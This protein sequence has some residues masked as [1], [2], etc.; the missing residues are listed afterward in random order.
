[1]WENFKKVC[2]VVVALIG[3]VFGITFYGT[4]IIE[5]PPAVVEIPATIL[6]GIPRRANQSYEVPS[7]LQ[8]VV[9][10]I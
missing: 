5:Q 8:N 2:A 9:I 6:Q 1:M 7:E 10:G 4:Y 3:V